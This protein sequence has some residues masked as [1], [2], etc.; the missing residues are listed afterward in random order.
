PIENI[1]DLRNRI[2]ASCETIR[3]I[4]GIF[5]RIRQSMRRRVDSCIIAGSDH[6]Q[7]LL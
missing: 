1:E 6:F 5:E 7:H 3:N 2:V 4:P